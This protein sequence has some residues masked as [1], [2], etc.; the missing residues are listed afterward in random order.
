MVE[1]AGTNPMSGLVFK[2][3]F[4]KNR[5]RCRTEYLEGTTVA[6]ERF[7]VLVGY[8]RGNGD[9]HV[10]LTRLMKYMV[11]PFLEIFTKKSFLNV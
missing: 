5:E 6:H 11:S 7:G 4:S 9:G 3:W 2:K 8:C 1:L 10:G